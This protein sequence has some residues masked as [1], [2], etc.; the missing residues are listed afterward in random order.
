MKRKLS[1]ILNYCFWPLLS[2]ELFLSV[3]KYAFNTTTPVKIFILIIRILCWIL[4]LFEAKGLF[5]QK[6]EFILAIDDK[7]SKYAYKTS[8]FL[9]ILCG[10]IISLPWNI[11]FFKAWNK[12]MYATIFFGI[13]WISSIIKF[14]FFVYFN[15]KGN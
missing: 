2:M 8:I 14:I 9:C 7:S 13:A 6:D 4:A 15:K 3:G 11:D 10:F 12:Q 5:E 1:L